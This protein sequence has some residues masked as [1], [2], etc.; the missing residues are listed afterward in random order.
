MPHTAQNLNPKQFASAMLVVLLLAAC[1]PAP[2]RTDTD[3]FFILKEGRVGPKNAPGFADC[4]LD[5]FDKAHFF[6]T[7]VTH[8]Q[9]RRADSF[10]VE[11][12]AG[13]TVLI[14]SADVFDD[15]RVVLNESKVAALINTSGQRE[16][17]DKCLGQYSSTK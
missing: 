9:Q 16:T 11:T 5:G 12:L 14:I 15:G 7:N 8:R 2:T 3:A 6:P 17:F 4:L 1:A 10:R 13:G